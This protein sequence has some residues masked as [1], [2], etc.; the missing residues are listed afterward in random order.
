MKTEYSIYRAGHASPERHEIDWP[1]DPGYDRIKTLVEPLLGAGE[2]LEHVAVLYNGER[3]DMFVSEV[4]QLQLT[5]RGPLPINAAA[6]AVYRCNWLT[7]HPDTNPDDL[8][9]I[10][11]VAVLFHRPVWF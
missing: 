8:P 7:H 5:T 6:T 2:P 1:D 3:H 10:A 9:N 11:G 4:G